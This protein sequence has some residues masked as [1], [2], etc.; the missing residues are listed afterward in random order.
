MEIVKREH[1]EWF[2]LKDSTWYIKPSN[3]TIQFNVKDGHGYGWCRA[4]GWVDSARWLQNDLNNEFWEATPEEVKHALIAEA[5]NRYKEGDEI[6][7]VIDNDDVDFINLCGN[8]HF[9]NNKL[10]VDKKFD[11]VLWHCIFKDGQWA[12]VISQEKPSLQDDIQAL[13]DRWPDINL[14]VIAEGKK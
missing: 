8:F 6:E 1:P 3:G 4:H 2:R 7:C 13:K 9:E 11:S 14:T 10:F 5:K 12:S